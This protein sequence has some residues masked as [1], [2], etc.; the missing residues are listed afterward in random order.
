MRSKRDPLGV[1]R[2]D[3]AVVVGE[4]AVDH[5]AHE[6]DVREAEPD[7]VRENVERQ[8]I[9]DVGEQLRELEHGLARQDH[10]LPLIIAG[11]RDARP[12]QPM[13]VGRD[14]LQRA[15]GDDQQHAVQVVADV[16]LRHREF[17]RLQKPAELALR[18][19]K[20]LHLILADADARVVGGRQAPAD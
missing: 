20:R 18:Q 19:R 2:R 7:L 17:G 11:D 9:V 12:G 3:H 15:L 5:L 1:G 8:R 14:R 10:F 13:A 16:L 4:L 6:L